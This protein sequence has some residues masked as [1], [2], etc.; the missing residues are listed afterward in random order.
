M[1]MNR[2]QRRSVAAGT[3][4][5]RVT[6][7]FKR[8]DGTLEESVQASVID[9]ALEKCHVIRVPPTTSTAQAKDIEARLTAEL[10]KPCLV[11]TRNIEF[12]MVEPVP[13]NEMA[14]LLKGIDRNEPTQE[15]RRTVA[16]GSTFA[17]A[18]A[19]ARD[20]NVAVEHAVVTPEEAASLE[21][22]EGEGSEDV[23]GDEP[24]RE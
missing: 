8:A 21:G 5:F 10:G 6:P 15:E 23:D 16:L 22:A 20:G 19:N 17:T 7:I 18:L 12:C 14:S 24:V 4:F 11:V 13:A 3:K 2:R 9:G 1:S